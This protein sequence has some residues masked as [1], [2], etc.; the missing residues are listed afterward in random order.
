M[1]DPKHPSV[2]V[3]LTGQD[4]NAFAILA[5]VSNA[6]RKAGVTREEISE[7]RKQATSGDYNNLLQVTMQWVEVR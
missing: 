3:R 5:R 4:G 1:S 2:R 7:Y 6:M